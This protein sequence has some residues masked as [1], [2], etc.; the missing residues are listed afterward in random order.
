M[1]EQPFVWCLV[2]N[3][4]R[5]PHPEGPVGD[6]R[7]GLKHFS[8]GTKLYCFPHAW[9]DGGDRLR[10]L[11][12]HRGGSK[13]IN[14]VIA[15][16]FLTNWRVQKVFNPQVVGAMEGY[17][18]NSEV[19]HEKALSALGLYRGQCGCVFPEEPSR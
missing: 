2:A 1:P 14:I 7:I 4:T 9:G 17:C 8:P 13:L 5:E 10:V 15:N 12:R 3:V 6:L 16:R 18:D 11:G 19:S